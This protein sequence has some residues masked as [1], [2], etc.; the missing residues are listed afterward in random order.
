ME[1][2]HQVERLTTKQLK[3]CP[4]THT[5]CRMTSKSAREKNKNCLTKQSELLCMYML[6]QK[7]FLERVHRRA[8]GLR[9]PQGVSVVKVSWT[10]PRVWRKEHQG[11][12]SESHRKRNDV[13]PPQLRRDA[14]WL[15][16]NT[17]NRTRK[18]RCIK[19]ALTPP[20]H[21]RLFAPP[22]Q[23][24]LSPGQTFRACG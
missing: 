16:N 22:P 1:R 12:R 6:T 13:D 5:P 19:T 4:A 7:S 3:S 8:R 24:P 20:S 18:P 21:P 14:D 10:F 11:L 23:P 15:G 2:R 9:K 17:I